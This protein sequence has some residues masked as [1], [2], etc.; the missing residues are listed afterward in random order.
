M[1]NAAALVGS[2]IADVSMPRIRKRSTPAGSKKYSTPAVRMPSRHSRGHPQPQF[3][4]VVTDHRQQH[5]GEVGVAHTDGV[6]VADREQWIDEQDFL[7]DYLAAEM[8]NRVRAS[9]T[10]PST[11]GSNTGRPPVSSIAAGAKLPDPGTRGLDL[12]IRREPSRLSLSVS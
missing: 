1:T 4:Q 6:V 9:L 7:F 12:P 3:E 8:V 2:S 5:R 10:C 11:M